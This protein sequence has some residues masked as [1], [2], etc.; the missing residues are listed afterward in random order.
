MSR[1][2]QKVSEQEG[3]EASNPC[4]SGPSLLPDWSENA[5]QQQG[6]G[7]EPCDGPRVRVKGGFQ[8][9]LRRLRTPRRSMPPNL[10]W[11]SCFG[12]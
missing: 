7:H 4:P 2:S 9:K 12:A 8:A 11:V 6:Q 3:V 1:V 10:S 5:H